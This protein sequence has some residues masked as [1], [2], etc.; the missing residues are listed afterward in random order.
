MASESWITRVA[1]A[2]ID[3]ERVRH[4]LSRL[5]EVWPREL[6]R[7]PEVIEGF[8]DEGQALGH[9]LSM[10]SISAEKLVSDPGALVWLASPEICRTPRDLNR[11]R[12]ALE[13]MTRGAHS[14][15][16]FD[17]RFRILRR[18]KQREMLRLALREVA[19]WSAVAGSTSELSYL[20]EVCL[21]AV[22]DAWR[23]ELARKFG[24]PASAFAVL[25]MGKLGGHELN[26]SSDIDLIFFYG[27][28]G[29]LN[30]RFS[31]RD[32][33]TRL[34]EKIVES[35]GGSDPG[36]ALFRV[37]LRLRPEGASGPL[38]RSI[39]SMEAYYAGYGATWERMALIK[40]RLVAGSEELGYEFMHRMQPF[41]YARSVAWDVV[42][43]ISAV[44]ERIEREIVGAAGLRRNVKLGYGGIR[45]IEFI[46]QALQLLHGARHAFLQERGTLKA[47]QALRQLQIIPAAQIETLIAAY[48]FLR[49]LEHRLQMEAEA[50]THLLPEDPVA[51]QRLAKSLGF[52]GVAAMELELSRHTNAVREIFDRLLRPKAERTPEKPRDLS[53]FRDEKHAGQALAD[54]DGSAASARFSPRIRRQAHQLEGLLLERLREVADPDAAL[55]RLVRFVERYGAR[56]LLLEMLL[57]NPRLLELL[58]RLF[59][60]SRVLGEIVL[61]QPQL[62]EEVT[63]RGQ[64]AETLRI[65]NYRAGLKAENAGPWMEV[66]GRYRLAQLVRI[67]VRDVLGLASLRELQGEYTALA[68]A[69]L[70]FTQEQLGYGGEVTI[71]AMGKFGGSELSYGA[72]LDLLFIG[73]NASAASEIVQAVSSGA[74][75]TLFAVDARLRPEG[76]AGPLVCSLVGYERYFADRAQLWEAQALTR[77]RPIS[78]P[79]QDEYSAL[80]KRIW[81]RFGKREDL[82]TEISAM[83]ER[84][85]LERSRGSLDFKT[86][87][88]GMM[89]LEFFTQALQMRFG[90]WEPNTLNAL[91]LMAGKGILPEDR[92]DQLMAGYLFLRQC[93]AALRLVEGK[94]VSA[95]PGE[96]R[97]LLQLAIRS[98]FRSPVEFLQKYD[99]SRRQIAELAVLG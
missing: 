79:R 29:E 19:G 22:V 6:P 24:Q 96:E 62:F 25:A 3:P 85:S 94:S 21:R 64:L 51:L 55:T 47:L 27:E 34:A 76:E 78:G 48:G 72:D 77:A 9:L 35:I 30:P 41:V 7:L 58:V 50:Q 40:A 37:D 23:A 75:G 60:A 12:G 99:E 8:P 88:G 13:F 97:Q 92:V 14:G 63:R 49:T 74:A 52:Q 95:L 91:Q 43:E 53:F 36:G 67:G 84:V 87:P 69:C 83:R 44:K 81:Q 20:A 89:Q 70:V 66:L 28:D 1:G 61:S 4:A 56:G 54:L 59:D 32:F 17:A 33:F 45:E 26:Y 2:A 31:Y 65:E 11:M 46:A 18:W 86:G 57:Q 5:E 82:F 38:V 16:E 73:E 98:G 80:A 71:V 10:S 15:G 90:V 39:A 68:E 93:E 42:E